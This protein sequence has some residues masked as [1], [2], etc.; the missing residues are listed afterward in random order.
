M[1]RLLS[2]LVI[3][4][5]A[6]PPPAT[7][8]THL[9]GTVTA[10]LSDGPDHVGLWEYTIL[11]QWELPAGGFTSVDVL[12]PLQDCECSCER[13]LIR[14]GNPSGAMNDVTLPCSQDLI[15]IY[16][17]GGNEPDG[18]EVAR[19]LTLAN[20]GCTSTAVGSGVLT[21]FTVF[22]PGPENSLVALSTRGAGVAVV[23]RLT[24]TMP[25]CASTSCAA[26]PIDASTWSLIKATYR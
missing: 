13:S 19:Y 22:G 11:F 5:C 18:R 26:L 8:A 1:A 25:L 24:G 10:Q 15:G 21:F 4:L 16:S 9:S 3:L 7:A 17:C 20:T 2:L 6:L 23:G 12:L 14:F